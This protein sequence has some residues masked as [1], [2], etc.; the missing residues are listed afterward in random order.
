MRQRLVYLEFLVLI[1][2][3]TAM[4]GCRLPVSALSSLGRAAAVGSRGAV[5]L[6]RTAA[7]GSRGAAA[8]G[9]RAALVEGAVGRSS[10]LAE[11]IAGPTG[12]KL[13]GRAVPRLGNEGT[14]AALGRA[15]ASYSR[16]PLG[17]APW[18][19]PIFERNVGLSAGPLNYEEASGALSSALPDYAIS[20]PFESLALRL[21]ATA[22]VGNGQPELARATHVVV[23]ESSTIPRSAT[24]SEAEAALDQRPQWLRD[25][26]VRVRTESMSD[27]LRNAVRQRMAAADIKI[28]LADLFGDDL[29]VR[30]GVPTHDGPLPG[31]SAQFE[32]RSLRDM[33]PIAALG[34]PNPSLPAQRVAAAGATTTPHPVDLKTFTRPQIPEVSAQGYRPTHPESALA[35][36]PPL[37]KIEIK[38]ANLVAL[39]EYG[40]KVEM[41]L[42][43]EH[44]SVGSHA[45]H[46]AH[47]L[48]HSHLDRHDRDEQRGT[49]ARLDRQRALL[50]G[51]AL[52]NTGWP[53]PDA[54]DVDLQNVN[55]LF[56]RPEAIGVWTRPI[57]QSDWSFRP[58]E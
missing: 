16:R 9:G 10:S 47:H 30:Y 58:E 38:K 35:D 25:A 32:T 55:R 44:E 31:A 1:C 22:S 12:A 20:D 41:Q 4:T 7:I 52:Q 19:D 42:R 37:S 54:S 3:A 8:W 15:S 29:A 14:K 17:G 2:L 56:V 28:A 34:E 13:F 27:G 18:I 50:A 49:Q 51:S 53:L 6:G 46:L 24:L 40:T 5:S 43:R 11:R 48:I 26:L 45:T 39:D 33:T 23:S 21:R 36:L 57:G